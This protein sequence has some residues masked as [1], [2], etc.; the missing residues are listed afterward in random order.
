MTIP[1]AALRVWAAAIADRRMERTGATRHRIPGWSCEIDLDDFSTADW[2]DCGFTAYKL[3]YLRRRYPPG[4]L[5]DDG[6]ISCLGRALDAGGDRFVDASAGNPHAVT[7]RRVDVTRGWFA[8]VLYLRHLGWRGPCQFRCSTSEAM[9]HAVNASAVAP[10]VYAAGLWREAAP[11]LARTLRRAVV[12][13]LER[14]HEARAA[15]RRVNDWAHRVASADAMQ[16]TVEQLD[17]EERRRKAD[18]EWLDA[19]SDA[20]APHD[21]GP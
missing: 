14:R 7:Y 12:H 11:L 2:S 13:R 3:G 8:D 15:T 16:A 6:C 9:L 20:G 5:P 19:A 10:A 18:D 1:A 21:D 4:D 17:G